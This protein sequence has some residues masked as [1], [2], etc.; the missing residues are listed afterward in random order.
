ML[1]EQRYERILN[2]LSEKKSITVN[3]IKELLQTSES[4][5]RRDITALHNA[6]K[7]K[8]VFGGAVALKHSVISD[9][10]T[11]AQK[12]EINVE[13]KKK[14]AK[15]ATSLI[16]KDDFVYLDAGTTTGYMID[17]LPNENIT[18]VTNAVEHAKRLAVQG[19]QVLLI[20]GQLKGSTEAL[21]GNFATELLGKFHF[22]KGFFGTNGITRKAGYTTPD[23][24]EALVKKAAMLQCS[25]CYVL[26]DNSKF[27]KISPVT[28]EEFN[29][30]VIITDR[31]IKGFENCNNIKVAKEIK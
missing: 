2:L 13:Q 19:R 15:Y 26:A 5:V 1:T 6:G 4:T 24:N 21:V 3:E 8:K 31:I 20:G 25:E 23:T 29:K 27:D 11:V 30:A 12:S 18:F 17:Y 16:E 22:T 7:L 10:P 28:F 14:I 9:E